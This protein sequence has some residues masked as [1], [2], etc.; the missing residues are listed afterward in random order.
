MPT[1]RLRD[2]PRRRDV[3]VDDVNVGEKAELDRL[4]AITGRISNPGDL[5]RKS[6]LLRSAMVSSWTPR[7]MEVLSTLMMSASR[8][9]SESIRLAP[10]PS[11]SGGCGFWTGFGKL[12][13]PVTR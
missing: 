4:E 13:R 8:P 12:S 6:A 9:A 2:L 1:A 11:R 7:A 10:P 3:V 5:F